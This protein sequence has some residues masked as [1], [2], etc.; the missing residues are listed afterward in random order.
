MSVLQSVQHKTRITNAA[1][2]SFFSAAA[3]TLYPTINEGT[4]PA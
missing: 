1:H 2:Q 3:M 4:D